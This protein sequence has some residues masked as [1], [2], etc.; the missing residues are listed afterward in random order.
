MLPP[1]SGSPHH[2]ILW[3]LRLMHSRTPQTMAPILKEKHCQH[4]R[5]SPRRRQLSGQPRAPSPSLPSPNRSCWQRSS[6]DTKKPPNPCP[7]AVQH[8]RRRP[9]QHRDKAQ[10]QQRPNLQSLR[11]LPRQQLCHLPRQQLC[12]L[13]RQQRQRRPAPPPPRR[14]PPHQRR[15][16]PLPIQRSTRG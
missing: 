14:P 6:R 1:R 12:H 15:R 11:A 4:R 3:F 2:Q 16:P 8:Q 10:P 5:W 7:R 9:R 13:P